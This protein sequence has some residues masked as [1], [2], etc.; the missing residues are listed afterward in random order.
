M[1]RAFALLLVAAILISPLGWIY[2]MPVAA[3]PIAAIVFAQE[4]RGPWTWWSVLLGVIAIAGFYWPH[5]LLGAMQP[6]RWATLVFTSAYFWASLAAWTWL[7]T[8]NH[9]F[10]GLTTRTGRSAK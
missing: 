8:E 6:N 1:D 5:P 7:M 9:R 4:R 3:G 10:Q 2:Y